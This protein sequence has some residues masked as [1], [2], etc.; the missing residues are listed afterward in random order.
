VVNPAQ[1]CAR[2]HS[3]NAPGPDAPSGPAHRGA[4]GSCPLSCR[5]QVRP[6][7]P[8]PRPS[9]AFS[10]SWRL[11]LRSWGWLDRLPGVSPAPGRPGGASLHVGLDLHGGSSCDGDMPLVHGTEVGPGVP[12]PGLHV[13]FDFH[14]LSSCV[15]VDSAAHIAVLPKVRAKSKPRAPTVTNHADDPGCGDKR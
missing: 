15:G 12:A 8:R 4:W 13:G 5:G 6:W 2:L 1:R 14:G 9:R 11:L 7:C 3:A 10:L